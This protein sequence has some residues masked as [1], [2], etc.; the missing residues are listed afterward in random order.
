MFTITI[1][2]N[3]LLN[4]M[5]V[6]IYIIVDLHCIQHYNFILYYNNDKNQFLILDK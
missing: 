4:K 1:N 2:Y 3:Q 5:F 6:A